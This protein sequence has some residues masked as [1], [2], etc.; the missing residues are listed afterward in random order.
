MLNGV[1]AVKI[2][3]R[4][5]IAVVLLAVVLGGGL[6]LYLTVTEYKPDAVTPVQVHQHQGET[7]NVQD[8]LTITSF[9]IGYAALDSDVDFFM[10]G[11]SM[12]RGLSRERVEQNLAKI[13]NF[14]NSTGSDLYVLQEVDEESTRSYGVNQKERIAQALPDYVYSYALNYR[15]GWVPVP[16]LQPMGRVASGLQT[17]SRFTVHE[18]TRYSLASEESWPTSIAHLKRCLLESRIPVSNGRELVIANIHLSAYDAGG[19]LRDAQLAFLEEY[20]RSEAANGNYV[21]IGG[22]WNHLLASNPQEFRAR[23]SANWPS[24]LQL[25]PEGV[26]SEFVWAYDENIPSVRNLD[27]SYDPQRTFTCTIDGF[28]VS[29]NVEVVNVTGHDLGFEFSDHH[30]VTMT[31]RL[32]DDTETDEEA[33]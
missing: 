21:I 5:V 14:L 6:V 31:F 1:M 4:A 15:V 7:V 27:A 17:L 23:F 25:L 3:L 29:P 32:I 33:E 28:L 2:L 30:P 11:G 24:W 12:S 8:E 26:L 16:L 10:D 22:D 13:I 19:K 18:S 9:N 20:V